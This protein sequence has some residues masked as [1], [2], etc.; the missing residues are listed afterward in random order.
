MVSI[1]YFV[2]MQPWTKRKRMDELAG[3]ISWGT[4]CE[5]MQHTC[6]APNFSCM[7]QVS[8]FTRNT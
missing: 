7:L 1:V 8:K 5:R 6:Q 4:G 3:K 2:A